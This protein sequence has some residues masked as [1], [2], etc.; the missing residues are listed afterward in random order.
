MVLIEIVVVVGVLSIILVIAIDSLANPNGP[1]VGGP[2]RLITRPWR[3]DYC[4]G[5][6]AAGQVCVVTLYRPWAWGLGSQAAACSCG[7]PVTPLPPGSV[8]TIPP[9]AVGPGSGGIAPV[10][11]DTNPQ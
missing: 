6:C 9:T 3:K 8:P 10:G 4:S 2:C 5:G 7:T 11:E 1:Q